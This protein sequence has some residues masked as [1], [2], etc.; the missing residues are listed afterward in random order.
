M[1]NI[2]PTEI[3]PEDLAK[4]RTTFALRRMAREVQNDVLSDGTIA[5]HI[6]IDL[7]HPIR[8]PDEVTIERKLLFSAFQAAADGE[9]IPEIIDSQDTKRDIQVEI[10]GDSAF[11]IYGTRRIR[12]PQ[13]ALLSARPERR[14]AIA[15]SL[16]NNNTLTIQAREQFDAIIGHP[17]YSHDDFFAACNIL[18]SSPE[19]F[20]DTLRE[21][22]KKGALSRTDF[23]PSLTPHWEN[24]TAKHQ[25]SQTLSEFIEEELAAERA[26]RIALDPGVAVDVISLTF[27][28]PELVPLE[29]MR[30]IDPEIM[31]ASLRR[32]M[33]LSDP[34]ALS[35][36]FDICADRVSTDN[37]FA[38]LGD[39]IL[40]RLLADQKGLL[41]E[42]A[43][44]ATA[45]IIASAHLAAHEVLRKQPVFWRRLAAASHASLVTRILGSNSAEEHPLLNW[46][47]R[48][49]GKLFYL[50]VLND[51]HV[52]P[53]WRPDWITPEYL[54][55]DIYGRLLASI[56]RLSDAAPPNWRRK[57]D[58]AKASMVKDVP[59]MAHTF[60]AILQGWR[61]PPADMPA[62]DTPI[63][64]MFAK[65]AAEPTI[66]NFLMFIQLTYTF[67]FPPDAREAVL[68][69][70]QSLRN[71]I[72]ATPAD[73]AQAALDL[74]A[75]IAARNRDAELADAVAVVSIERLVATQDVDRLLPTASV[76]VEC[77]AA[78]TD[79]KEALTTLA[80]R[81]ENLAFVASAKA[82][83]EALDI[84]RILQAVNEDL[85]P[86]L[87]RA[88][89]T[90]RLGLPRIAPA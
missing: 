65:L 74:A 15:T 7:S 36:G 37:R 6:A 60:P 48:E 82:L 45:F 14:R 38:D 32:L 66:E 24:I 10:E 21:V 22:A 64:E 89:A 80:R 41:G 2:N 57:I 9:P 26:A 58:D 79:R 12:F 50:S 56:Q 13:A 43:T 52:E 25:T 34:L 49:T 83:P 51:A 87:G 67:G 29:A 88:I 72:A 23:L 18:A 19:T 63:G 62:S 42:L 8:L 71:G 54:A 31:I 61:T 1:T 77:T 47:M 70:V 40:D 86:L 20:A 33:E 75:F 44:F 16:L 46:A 17:D 35:G 84:F 81:L 5:A 28:A 78:V 4:L 3:P 39:A 85:S 30:Q 69:A 76:I 90:A 68:K 55:A 53:R 59:P 27:D 73:H 11:L